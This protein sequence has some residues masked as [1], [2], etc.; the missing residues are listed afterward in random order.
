MK[1]ERI[2]RESSGE[3]VL[4]M[5]PTG[6]R[7]RADME[8]ELGRSQSEEIGRAETVRA[9]STQPVTFRASAPLL[10]RLDELAAQEHRTRANMIQHI[11]WSYIHGEENV[12]K[13]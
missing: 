9:A 1:S 5:A 11:L 8:A 7:T 13:R 10:A 3:G 2:V 12:K 4:G 6:K